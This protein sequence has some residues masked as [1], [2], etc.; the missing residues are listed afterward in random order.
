MVVA[1]SLVPT[2]KR[3]GRLQPTDFRSGVYRFHVHHSFALF[4]S[5]A[6]IGLSWTQRRTLP[7]SIS[8][9]GDRK[10]RTRPGTFPTS[11]L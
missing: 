5:S 10:Q 8:P 4:S 7:N 2:K 6:V 11:S 1:M 9:K 3:G